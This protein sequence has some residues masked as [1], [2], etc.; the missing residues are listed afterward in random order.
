[1]VGPSEVIQLDGQSPYGEN[2]GPDKEL[3]VGKGRVIAPACFFFCQQPANSSLRRYSLPTVRL[4]VR[5]GSA[6]T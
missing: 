3:L 4:V 2:C 1:M 5:D 6:I